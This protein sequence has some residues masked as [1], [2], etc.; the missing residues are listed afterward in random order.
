MRNEGLDRTRDREEGDVQPDQGRP[1]VMR[2]CP[3]VPAGQVQERSFAP[4]GDCEE[5]ERG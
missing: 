3:S 4:E 1:M 2:A 5:A